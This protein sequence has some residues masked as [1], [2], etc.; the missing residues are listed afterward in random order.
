[1]KIVSKPLSILIEKKVLYALFILFGVAWLLTFH[2]RYIEA[3]ECILGEY[4]YSFLNEGIVRVKSIPAIQDWDVR[5]FPHHRFFTWFGAAV[6]GIFG[7][8]ITWLKIAIL[9][10]YGLFFIFL[11]HYFKLQNISKDKFILAA[12]LAFTAP[13]LL[14][15]SY[16]FRPD[17]LLMTEGMG[18]LYFISKYRNEKQ[19]KDLVFAGAFAGLGLLTHLNGAA[20]C[21]AGFFFLLMRKEFKALIPYTLA[22]AVVGGIYF[23]ELLPDN[24][25]QKFIDQLT[26]W[27][28]VNHGENFMGSGPISLVTGRIQKLLSE[29]QRFFWG[30]KVMGFSIIFFLSLILSFRKLKAHH[31]DLLVFMLVLVLSLNIFGSHIAERYLLF[32]YGPMAIITSLGIFYL[33]ED[34]T[35]KQ[36]ILTLSVLVHFVFS[37]MMIVK[38]LD[39]SEPVPENNKEIL[40]HIS[41]EAKTLVPYEMIYNEFPTRDLYV[42]KTY[43]YLQESMPNKEMTQLQLFEKASELGMEYIVINRNLAADQGRWFHNW[44]IEKNSYYEE[45]HKD[46]KALILKKL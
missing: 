43:E 34:K 18:L 33:V 14:L 4:S 17:V 35:W 13:I 7:W 28:T 16:S 11:Y 36:A 45:Y 31:T 32:Y 25:F 24:N 26:N 22:G 30:D 5:M 21:I 29:H 1:M 40:S 20:F 27:P 6:I 8:S 37:C 39:R 46:Q 15:K 12:L 10:W 41:E 2:N 44:E 19:V 3:D 42:Y 38:I 23:I 9:P